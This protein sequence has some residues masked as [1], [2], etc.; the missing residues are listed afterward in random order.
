M[1]TKEISKLFKEAKANKEFKSDLIKAKEFTFA[2]AEFNGD[3]IIKTMYLQ[4]YVGWKIGKGIH[5]V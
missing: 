5:N 1:I 3:K 2:R 4:M